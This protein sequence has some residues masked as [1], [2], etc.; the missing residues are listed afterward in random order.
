MNTN[1]A[2]FVHQR[3]IGGKEALGK[4]CKDKEVNN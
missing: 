3:G 4:H 1:V 2:M